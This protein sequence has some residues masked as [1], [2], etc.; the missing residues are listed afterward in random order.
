LWGAVST[1]ALM[2]AHSSLRRKPSQAPHREAQQQPPSWPAI[3]IPVSRRTCVPWAHGVVLAGEA[4]ATSARN[5]VKVRILKLTRRRSHFVYGELE[6]L[7]QCE[8]VLVSPGI[9]AFQPLPELL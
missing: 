2:S 8:L 5:H 1:R 7:P 9:A 3:S 4:A 6:P